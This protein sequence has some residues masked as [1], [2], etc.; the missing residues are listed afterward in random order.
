MCNLQWRTHRT[1]ESHVTHGRMK[2][3][4]W[5][6]GLSTST[7]SM[8]TTMTSNSYHSSDSKHSSKFTVLVVAA[9]TKEEKRKRQRQ[10]EK[11]THNLL[12]IIVVFV[13]EPYLFW[14]YCKCW[15]IISRNQHHHTYFKLWIW[16][17]L[18]WV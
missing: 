7:M 13:R 2:R 1:G 8:S 10:Q 6:F 17:I 11:Q 14:D 16:E 3:M 18:A 12:V 15:V 4:V 9:F 5:T